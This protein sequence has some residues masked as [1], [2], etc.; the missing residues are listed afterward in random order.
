MGS[1]L[2]KWLLIG[3]LGVAILVTVGAA[4]VFFWYRSTVAESQPTMDGEVSV[5]GLLDTVEI[6]RDNWGVPHVFARNESDLFFG[7]GYT[8]AQDRLWQM[9]FYRRVGQGRLSEIFGREA[10][11]VDRFFRTLAA[12]RTNRSLPQDLVFMTDAFAAGVNAYIENR[13]D[14]LPLEFKLLGFRPDSWK[15][16]DYFSILTLVSWGLSI[17]WKVDLVAADVLREVGDE[18]FQEAFP[19][20]TGNARPIVGEALPTRMPTPP[21][22]AQSLGHLAGFS[23]GPA[24]NN[25]VISGGRT[26]TGLPL[27]ANDTHMTL[28]NPSL[29]WE[30]HLVCPTIDATGFAIPGLPGLPIG[31]NRQVAWGVTNVMVDD[32]DF[33]IEQLHPQDPLQY[34]YA[35]RWEKMRTRV[36]TLRI[37][38]AEPLEIEIRMTRHG[39][40]VSNTASEAAITDEN[41]VSARWAFFEVDAPARAAYRLLKAGDTSEVVAA[42]EFWKTPGQNFV[43]ADTRGSIG[44]WCSA[45]VPIRPTGN[46]LLPHNGW[47]GKAEWTGF[48]AFEKLPHVIDPE[49]GYI[50]S[51]NNPVAGN[52]YPQLISTYWEPMDRISRI[53]HLIEAKPRLSVKD[54]M[55]MQSDVISPLATELSVAMRRVLEERLEEFQDKTFRD[56]LEKWDFQMSRDSAAAA[57]VETTYLKL[58][59]N[60]FKDELG[61][62]LYDRYVDLTIFA[63]RALRHILTSGRSAWLDDVRTPEVETLAVILQKSMQQAFA[64]LRDRW[65]PA[66]DQWYWGRLHTLTFRHVLGK[67]EPLNRILDLGP[68]QTPGS[69]LTVNKKQYDYR[70]PFAVQ[71]GVSQRM[72]VDLTAPQT[73]FHVLPTGQSGLLGSPHYQDQIELYLNDRY[74]PSWLDR[75]DIERH[76]EAKLVLTPR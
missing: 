63:P 66:A 18:K 22:P 70:T 57:M 13:Q 44:Y 32:V 34:R 45:A 15:P 19:I 2:A 65:G 60:I 59:E 1:R 62:N 27:L 23:P 40:V 17:G 53:R 35:N 51:A 37:K 5:S 64:D 67:R 74:R 76:A 33:Y 50:A 69:H 58:L 52:E 61:S 55:S 48:V 6:I 4:A 41:V 24:S 8:M 12:T 36:E 16:E 38:D 3:S 20:S 11:E 72:I 75:S 9:E 71:E 43:F 21:A 7:L 14:R 68:F 28:S 46:G 73:A 10:L 56:I 29:W 54:M 30:V 49:E 39:P 42:L 25:W 26:E 47:T 31:R